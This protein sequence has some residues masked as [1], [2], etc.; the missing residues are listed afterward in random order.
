MFTLPV[1]G[2]RVNAFLIYGYS[3]NYAIKV[4]LI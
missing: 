1:N 3:V 2:R 4:Q